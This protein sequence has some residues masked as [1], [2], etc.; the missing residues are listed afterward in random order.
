MRALL[1]LK[2]LFAIRNPAVKLEVPC[3]VSGLRGCS[4]FLKY[5]I[6][7]SF[8]VICKINKGAVSEYHVIIDLNKYRVERN[9]LEVD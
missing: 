3:V 5:W 2:V 1:F 8:S 6:L 4:A 7:V 9:L